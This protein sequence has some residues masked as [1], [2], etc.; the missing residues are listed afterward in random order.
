M[1]N[2]STHQ[3]GSPIHR[4]FSSNFCSSICREEDEDEDSK[5]LDGSSDTEDLEDG[6]HNGGVLSTVN[7]GGPKSSIVSLESQSSVSFSVELPGMCHA[8]TRPCGQ[9]TLNARRPEEA[10][11]VLQCNE[12]NSLDEGRNSIVMRAKLTAR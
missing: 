4:S 9:T 2:N 3:R 7:S 11:M 1:H 8:E 10:D 12:I 6:K 5:D